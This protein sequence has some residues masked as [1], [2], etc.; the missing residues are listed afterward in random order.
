MQKQPDFSHHT[1]QE[2][3]AM[4]NSEAG[5]QL[6][7]TLNEKHSKEMEQAFALA[8]SGE[9]AQLK[10]SLEGILSNPETRALLDQLRG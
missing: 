2:A 10:K 6:L 9:Y 7:S 3:A 5:K 4:A 8:A 1:I